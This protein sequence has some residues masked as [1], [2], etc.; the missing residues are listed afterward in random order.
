MHDS[1]PSRE[2]RRGCRNECLHR[3][4]F[5]PLYKSKNRLLLHQNIPMRGSEKP[6]HLPPTMT[7]M[8]SW[9]CR[10][11]ACCAV[12]PV[13]RLPCIA[14]VSPS[15]FCITTILVSLRRVIYTYY[16]YSCMTL[17]DRFVVI[18]GKGMFRC[19]TQQ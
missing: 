3:W 2:A 10:P 15:E 17:G 18:R 19:K 13:D 7:W 6:S 9:P 5:D 16:I 4:M 12:K 11:W 8:N 14:V 1:E